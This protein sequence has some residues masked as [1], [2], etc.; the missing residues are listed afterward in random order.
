MLAVE[1]CSDFQGTQHLFGSGKA[2]SVDVLSL[3][4]SAFQN[5][6]TAGIENNACGR[7]MWVER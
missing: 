2:E 3:R 4:L 7:N 1:T 5:K 6:R